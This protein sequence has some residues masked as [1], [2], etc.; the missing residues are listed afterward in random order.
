MAIVISVLS[1]QVF[2]SFLFV[3]G[4]ESFGGSVFRIALLGMAALL[5]ASSGLSRTSAPV[6]QAMLA[7]AALVGWMSLSLMWTTDMASG[8]RQIS[9]VFTA[10][11]LLFVLDEFIQRG[12]ELSFAFICAI[13]IGVGIA[14][15][16]FYEIRT[17]NHFYS[18]LLEIDD[19]DTS[20]S[21]VTD[22]S[23]WFT[24][25]NPNDLS[26]HLAM[27]IFMAAMYITK[28]GWDKI[29]YVFFAGTFLYL[30]IFQ[31]SRLVAAS[32]FVFSIVFFLSLTWRRMTLGTGLAVSSVLLTFIFMALMVLFR[33]RIDAIDTSSFIRLELLSSSAR[34]SAGS[35][36]MGAGSGSFESTIIREGLTGRTYG[37]LSPHNA[38][39]RVLAENG[40]IGLGLFL[41][42]VV[43]PLFVV[44]PDDATTRLR[45][46]V[47]GSVVALPF[48]LSAGSDPISAS[49]MTMFIALVWIAARVSRDAATFVEP[50]RAG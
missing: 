26:V 22:N 48:L 3:P 25:G 18:S 6:R 50:E 32:V 9:Y 10:L 43:G 5:F 20:L 16:A 42:I 36:F 45:A 30:I 44:A 21:Y 23:A 40:L 19:Y 39:G 31:H 41:Y 28:S 35:F 15:F 49:S 4:L 34:M 14:I 11:L 12:R 46:F 33:D 7:T 24:F 27:L 47:V 17:G 8:V 38:F 37:V 13:L 1:L 29:G 2:S